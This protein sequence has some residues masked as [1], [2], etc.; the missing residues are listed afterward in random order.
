[1]FKRIV[2]ASEMS[3][4]EFDIIACLKSFKKL[5]VEE[6]LLLQ[7]I[8]SYEI[9]PKASTFFAEVMEENLRRQKEQLTGEGYSVD[10]RLVTGEM[11][12][13]INRIAKEE[14]YDLI[15]T[16]AAEHTLIGGL[17]FGGVANEVIHH[18][19]KPVL[20]IRL[21]RHRENLDKPPKDCDLTEHILFPTDFSKN[22][23]TAFGT[24]KEMVAAGIKKITLVH[25]QD[26]SRI[27]PYLKDKLHDFNQ[28]DTERLESMKKSLMEVGDA[29]VEII[30]RLGSPTAELL[31]IIEEKSISLV[32]MGSQGRGYIRE[33]N[34]GSVAQNLSRH[35]K[36]SILLIPAVRE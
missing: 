19:S 34:L 16:A 29:E 27:M 8:N 9:K 12:D 18:A 35:S 25:I 4:G 17:L 23:E 22:A 11:K 24:L 13:E 7:C 28:M 20:L 10:T 33:L 26:E 5:G 15:V 30:L 21:S 31:K 14:D 6:C 36:S 2:I 32:V 1:M 3:R